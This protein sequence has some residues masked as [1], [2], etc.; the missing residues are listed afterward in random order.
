MDGMSGRI[1]IVSG[2]SGVGKTTICG[3]LLKLPSFVPSISATTRLSRPGERHGVD[4]VFMNRE[5]FERARQEGLFLE[6]AN[7]YDNYYGTPKGPVEEK[8]RTGKHVLLNVDVQGAAQIREKGLPVLSFFL[9]PPSMEVLRERI[10]K[11][12]DRAEDIERRMK[13]AEREI[14]RAHEYDH[15]LVNEIVEDTVRDIARIVE[16]VCARE[17]AES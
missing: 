6:W 4:Y 17:T 12:G 14:A 7:V 15:R 11:R 5:A 10:S 8:L 9:L 13:A 3:R 1:V 2:P 16:E